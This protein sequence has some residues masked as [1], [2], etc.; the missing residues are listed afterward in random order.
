MFIASEPTINLPLG[1][2][3]LR[4]KFD[5]FQHLRKERVARGETWN[6]MQPFLMGAS[7]QPKRDRILQQR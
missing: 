5:L 3:S 6:L 4:Q 7:T 2:L 1:S